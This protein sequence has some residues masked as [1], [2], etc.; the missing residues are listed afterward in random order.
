ME[1]VLHTALVV[2]Q[3]LGYTGMCVYY[4]RKTLKDN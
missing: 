1:L 4:L 3:I 2:S